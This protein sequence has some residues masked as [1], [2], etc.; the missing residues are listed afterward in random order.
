[1][2]R[3]RVAVI[4]VWPLSLACSTGRAALTNATQDV[5]WVPVAVEHDV[6]D[7]VAL[8]V[9]DTLTIR[10]SLINKSKRP[11]KVQH[12]SVLFI[13]EGH[14]RPPQPDRRPASAHLEFPSHQSWGETRL[15][16]FPNPGAVYT[17]PLIEHILQPGDG[18]TPSL[19][20]GRSEYH[21]PFDSVGTYSLRVCAEVNAVRMCD[22]RGTLVVVT[23]QPNTR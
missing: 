11:V 20:Y 23:P 17:A 14:Y 16:V 21:V 13:V 5:D 19:I 2:T 4:L 18:Y 8:R 10:P 6:G 3:T 22:R 7:R 15:L 12:G 1:M 9:G